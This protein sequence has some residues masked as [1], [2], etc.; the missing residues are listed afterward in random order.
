MRF[1][2]MQNAELRIK[3]GQSPVV[4]AM[5]TLPS[6]CRGAKFCAYAGN[7]FVGNKIGFKHK[8]LR[9][10]EQKLHRLKIKV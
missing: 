8:K 2:R 9:F 10:E 1:L 5:C 6:H 3:N 7:Y 4:E